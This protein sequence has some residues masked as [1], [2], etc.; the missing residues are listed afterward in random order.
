[1]VLGTRDMKG[2]LRMSKTVVG[3][4]WSWNVLTESLRPVAGLGDIQDGPGNSSFMVLGCPDC[5]LGWGDISGWSW[6]TRDMKGCLRMSK[7]V[8]GNTGHM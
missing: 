4:G 2:C 8:V 1:M 6:G 3:P 7:T 5:W